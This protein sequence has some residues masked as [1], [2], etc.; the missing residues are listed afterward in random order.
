VIAAAGALKTR[1]ASIASRY[2]AWLADGTV[3]L[4]PFAIIVFNT[5][6]DPLVTVLGS[7]LLALLYFVILW[8]P[9]GGGKTVGMRIYRLRVVRTDGHLLSLPRAFLRYV[10]LFLMQLSL[11]GVISV[12]LDD[13]RRGWHDNLADSLVIA[14]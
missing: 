6:P 10:G 12:L 4:V 11:V 9:L 14:E 5:D 7:Q 2:R 3:F 1:P 13:Q 8:S